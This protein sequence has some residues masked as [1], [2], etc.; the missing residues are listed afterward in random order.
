MKSIYSLIAII[1]SFFCFFT[2][3]NPGGVTISLA[4]IPTTESDTVTV[5]IKNYSGVSITVDKSVVLEKEENGKWVTV[6][7]ADGFG[8][9]ETAVKI[10]NCGSLTIKINI[11]EAYGHKLEKGIYR[12]TKD[13]MSSGVFEI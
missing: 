10:R 12:I 13:N 4:E 5:V 3:G 11:I 6:P 8:F 9:E 1:L 2:G 7:T